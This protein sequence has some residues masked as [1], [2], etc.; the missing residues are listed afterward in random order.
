[1]KTIP[2][3]TCDDAIAKAFYSDM[4]EG[5]NYIS[6]RRNLLRKRAGIREK[7]RTVFWQNKF[8]VSL[9]E[10]VFHTCFHFGN[11][12]NEVVLTRHPNRTEVV[13]FS[14]VTRFGKGE[15]IVENDV[16]HK[17]YFVSITIIKMQSCTHNISLLNLPWPS[18]NSQ[19][20]TRGKQGVSGRIPS[21]IL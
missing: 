7:D 8:Q 1:M 14:F 21:P 13:P 6:W 5:E 20:P 3:I 11:P 18:W 17:H 2:A 9:I 16:P 19:G 15:K 12:P 10:N 4:L